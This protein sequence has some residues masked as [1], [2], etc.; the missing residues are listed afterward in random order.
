MLTARPSISRAAAAGESR[1]PQTGWSLGFACPWYVGERRGDERQTWKA[2]ALCG[3]RASHDT[4]LS[5][6]QFLDIC[7]EAGCDAFSKT[8]CIAG[9]R[10]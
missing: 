2:V 7:H 9:K 4:R 6:P 5:L 3:C 10:G 1:R 8:S